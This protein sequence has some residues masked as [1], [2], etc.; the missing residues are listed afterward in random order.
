MVRTYK[1]EKRRPHNPESDKDGER[2]EESSQ[3]N[4]G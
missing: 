1:T 2:E 3:E 4:H